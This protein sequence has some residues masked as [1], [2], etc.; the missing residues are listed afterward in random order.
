MATADTPEGRDTEVFPKDFGEREQVSFPPMPGVDMGAMTLNTPSH[1]VTMQ[2]V[3]AQGN[4][5]RAMTYFLEEG[6]NVSEDKE[7]INHLTGYAKA[8]ND[9]IAA[10]QEFMRQLGIV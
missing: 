7:Y 1:L 10:Q 3:R 2:F 8:Q 6:R 4:F 5:I 9:M